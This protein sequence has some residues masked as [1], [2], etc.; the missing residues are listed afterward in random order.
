M[1]S[2]KFDN[3]EVLAAVR[4][5]QKRDPQAFTFLYRRYH[6]F[7]FRTVN[8]IVRDTTVT[9]DICGDVWL[10][11]WEKIPTF[12]ENA[13]IASWISR[14]AIN[15]SLM[16]FRAKKRHL[17][18]TTVSLEDE[19]YQDKKRRVPQLGRHDGR[20]VYLAERQQLISAINKIPPLH[21]TPLIMR[22]MYGYSALEISQAM[23]RTIPAIKSSL[24]RGTEQVKQLL[25]HDM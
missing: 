22:H 23:N 5:A 25:T 17:I 14:I 20:M 19:V 16:Y 12:R 1:D 18:S 13:A 24:A 7:I 11:V 9:P 6:M 3:E 15:E 2:N 10:K 4:A 8:K 21:R